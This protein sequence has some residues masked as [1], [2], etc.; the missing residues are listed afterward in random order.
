VQVYEHA[1]GTEPLGQCFVQPSCIASDIIS[2]IANK[3]PD[4]ASRTT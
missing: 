4:A 1:S 3:D 2:P